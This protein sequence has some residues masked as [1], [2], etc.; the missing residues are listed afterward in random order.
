MSFWSWNTDAGLDPIE[1]RD[2][3]VVVGPTVPETVV[4]VCGRA[5]M[6]STPHLRSLLLHLIRQRLSAVTV[7]DIAGVTKLDTSGIAALLEVLALARQK[8]VKLRLVGVHGQPS[9][10]VEL[11]NLAEV[12]SVSGSEVVCS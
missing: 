7:I 2:L 9:M 4:P 6:Q 11:T 10:L 1:T 5:T 8:S 12:F 3:T